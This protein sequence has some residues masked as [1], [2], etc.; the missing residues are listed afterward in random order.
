[1]YH[2]TSKRTWLLAAAAVAMGLLTFT[3]AAAIGAPPDEPAPVRQES[4]PLAL[5]AGFQAKDLNAE[6]GIKS[7]L[8]K[9]TERAVT[10]GDFNRMLAELAKQDKER[11]REFKG[12]DQARLDGIIA[13][14]QTQWKAKY[15]HDFSISD[16]NLVFDQRYAMVS[17]EVSDPAV[18]LS[19]WP[20]ASIAGEAVTAGSHS[21]ANTDKK[22]ER[23]A[24][25]NKGRDVALFRFAASGELPEITVSMIHQLPAFWRVDIPN[26]RTGEQIYNDLVARLTY[27]RDHQD[28]W[29]DDATAGYRMVA[30]QVVAAMYGAPMNGVRG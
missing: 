9:L 22:Q 23:E 15:G 12:V 6:S 18:A 20:V 5:P 13:Q 24:K 8:V 11:A 14:I 19:N 25:L 17:G 30:H 10:K 26:D 27:I 1:M 4:Q 3:P 29:P 21:N 16:K 28:L 7:G 2:T